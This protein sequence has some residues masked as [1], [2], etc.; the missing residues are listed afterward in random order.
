MSSVTTSPT[1]H[2]E[3]PL[4]RSA[5]GATGRGSRTHP[6]AP[7]ALPIDLPGAHTRADVGS[8]IAEF[9]MVS[10]L[11]SLIFA[12][13]LQLGLALHVRNTVTDSAVAGARQAGLA[14]QQP[15]DGAE[16]T[17]ALVSAGI[18]EAYAQDIEV[19]ESEAGGTRIV[20][21]TVTTPIPVLGLLGPQGSW[22]LSGRALVEDVDG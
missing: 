21:V 6:P 8:A 17:R 14:D 4:R 20:V 22:E 15:S 13:V 11:L 18:G 1:P 2:Q 3:I 9:V 19:V 10:A 16:L 7:A 5:L 12:S